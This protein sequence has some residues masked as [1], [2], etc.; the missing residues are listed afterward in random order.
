M[1][2]RVD[3]AV[4]TAAADTGMDL[5]ELLN[6]GRHKRH[7]VLLGPPPH[8]NFD[9]WKATRPLAEREL[10]DR[11]LEE[12]LD[13]EARTPAQLGIRVVAHRTDSATTEPTFLLGEALTLLRTPFRLLLEDGVTDR[14]FI[15]AA[16][17]E[18]DRA[19]L[20]RAERERWLVFEHGGGL[21]SIARLFDVA[22]PGGLGDGLARL[23]VF[24]VYDSDRLAPA[25]PSKRSDDLASKC[26][27]CGLNGPRRHHQLR[28]RMIENYLPLEALQR[29]EASTLGVRI[30]AAAVTAWQRLDAVQAHHYN[31]KT[32]FDGDINRLR[33]EKHGCNLVERNGKSF[34][35]LYG[36]LQDDVLH[37]LSGGFGKDIADDFDTHADWYTA[38]PSWRYR[39]GAEQ[40]LSELFDALLGVL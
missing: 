7:R 8:D 12:C 34:I 6:M 27:A 13:A 4:F 33:E 40:E 9:T 15:L 3:D 25:K 35:D 36:E 28:R 16:A 1:R 14:A 18:E 2:V 19:V 24:L 11:I 32:G 29:R 26:A 22:T 20:S 37:A 38:N 30:R 17:T 10:F 5:V 39:S 23:R 21:T 31:M